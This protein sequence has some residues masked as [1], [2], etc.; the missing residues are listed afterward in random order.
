MWLIYAIISSFLNAVINHIDKQLLE[1]YFKEGGVETL[2][3]FSTLF[4]VLI[5]PYAIYMNPDVLSIK[6][7]NGLIMFAAGMLNV[8][9]LYCYFKAL[10][11]DE[12]TI[13]ILYYQLVPVITLALGWFILGETITHVQSAAMVIVILG[14]LVASLDLSDFKS[15][16]QMEFKWKTLGYM[17]VATTCWAAESTIGKIVVL[18][19]S[20]YHSIFWE[21]IALLVIGLTVL[22]GEQL[23]SMIVPRSVKSKHPGKFEPRLRFAFVKAIKSNSRAIIGVNIASEGIYAT[24]NAFVTHAVAL[25]PVALVLLF[26]PTQAV[27]VFIIGLFL[28]VFFPKIYREKIGRYDLMVKVGAMCITGAGTVLLAF[29]S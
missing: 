28:T 19:E 25:A 3:L 29:N 12:P 4:A 15:L 16:G 7:E 10:E 17:L 8:I 27:F 2:M 11:V 6:F 23:L 18:D 13:V 24:S 1:R 22:F 5:V 14:T 26:Q 9:L 21:A 20:V